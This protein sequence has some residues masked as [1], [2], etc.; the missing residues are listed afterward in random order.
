VTASRINEAELM[1]SNE[2]IS[3]LRPLI[4]ARAPDLYGTCIDARVR[5]KVIKFCG[6]CHLYHPNGTGF[7]TIYEEW[8]TTENWVDL[9]NLRIEFK[10]CP[11]GLNVNFEDG[12]IKSTGA[13]CY[14][15]TQKFISYPVQIR[16]IEVLNFEHN[17]PGSSFQLVYDRALRFNL[18]DGFSFVLTTEQ[19]PIMGGIDFKEGKD[20][21][22]PDDQGHY[23]PRVILN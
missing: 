1:L 18:D 11:E 3:L 16:S 20:P 12:L 2:E 5:D 15:S 14:V 19:G 21:K 9:H 13:N 8:Q 7:L 6:G 4:G 17:E 23:R 10:K 22:F